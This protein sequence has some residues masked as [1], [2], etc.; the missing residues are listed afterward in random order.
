[1]RPRARPVDRAVDDDPVKPRP[2]RAAQVKARQRAQ[3]RQEGLLRDVLGRG[4]VA[5]DEQRGAVGAAPVAREELL[6]GVL[7]AALR[8][9]H[10]RGVGDAARKPQRAAQG[11]DLRTYRHGRDGTPRRGGADRELERSRV[12]GAHTEQ[13]G[14]GRPRGSRSD[15]DVSRPA[16]GILAASTY[17]AGGRRSNPQSLV[18]K[19]VD[20]LLDHGERSS[21]QE[22]LRTLTE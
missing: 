15:S 6:D 22:V 21:R 19:L 10:E 16:G 14:C 11:G 9:A 18:E 2:Q 20:L 4:A 7:R 1:V 5:G 12:V 13:Y 17:A 3:R 8:G